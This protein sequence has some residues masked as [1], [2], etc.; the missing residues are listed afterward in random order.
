M[1]SVGVP[2]FSPNSKRLV[3]TAKQGN[4]WFVVMDGTPGPAYD[5]IGGNS[6]F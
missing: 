6:S 2:Q 3:Y 4:K 5:G 1:G